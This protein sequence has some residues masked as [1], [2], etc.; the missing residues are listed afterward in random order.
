[1][2]IDRAA[3]RLLVAIDGRG[4]YPD[5]E[6]HAKVLDGLRRELGRAV[7]QGDFVQFN[8]FVG[9]GQARLET[10]QLEA[11]LKTLA[12]ELGLLKDRV[13]ISW[14]YDAVTWERKMD[15]LDE[16]LRPADRR[17]ETG[18]G[19]A[20]VMIYP[21]R[22]ELSRYL[23]GAE[24]Y[25]DLRGSAVSEEERGKAAVETI[26]RSVPGLEIEHK[27]TI[28]FRLHLRPGQTALRT[29]QFRES[30]RP[31]RRRSA[32]RNPA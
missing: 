15:G 22:T 29:F 20:D 31:S 30:C 26:R 11:I 16:G 5:G 12:A 4:C 2:L 8:I 1:M 3:V 7:R 25:V 14:T 32:S 13:C 9:K 19:D 17:D 21:V 10:P 18:I 6:F 23:T 27:R 28:N 24:L